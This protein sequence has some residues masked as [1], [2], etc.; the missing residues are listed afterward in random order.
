[1]RKILLV[2]VLTLVAAACRTDDEPYAYMRAYVA[3]QSSYAIAPKDDT[4]K[5]IVVYF[6][7]VDTDESVI[8][9]DDKHERLTHALVDAGYAVVASN[10]GGN[11]FGNAAS[12]NSYIALANL[13]REHYGV[14]DV[15]FLAESMGAIAALRIAASAPTPERGGPLGVAAIS[16]ALDLGD[17]PAQFVPAIDAAFA[18]ESIDDANP[19]A[20][21]PA[22]LRGKPVRFY[23][24]S[25]DTVVP[26]AQAV[27][28]AD[29]YG[30]AAPL[31]IVDCAGDHVD[32][33]CMQ[34]A[35]IVAWF[36]SL[37]GAAS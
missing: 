20:I 16:P 15:Y 36:D 29:K 9:G 32:E 31:S 25:A 10:A 5:A 18:G 22:E 28:F 33:S 37:A 13:A 27:A 7:G 4:P 14:K 6:H 21:D 35:A 26:R 34:G 23:V 30:A 3:G 24:S 17:P 1:M 8:T 2:V 19:M 12:R 11:V